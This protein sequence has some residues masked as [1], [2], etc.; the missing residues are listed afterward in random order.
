MRIQNVLPQTFRLA[1][2]QEGGATS[3]QDIAIP[4]DNQVD[5]PIQIGGNVRDVVLVVSGTTRFTHQKAAYR[6]SINP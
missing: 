2:I 5:V 4:A 3:V 6:Y 1:V